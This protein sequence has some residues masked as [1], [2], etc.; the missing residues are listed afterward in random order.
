MNSKKIAVY[1]HD[2]LFEILEEVKDKFNFDIIKVDEKNFRQIKNDL[3]LHLINIYAPNG[4]PIE[5][6][7]KFSYKIKW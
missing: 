1:Q 3:N 4:N 5:S 2:I 7:E 6:K